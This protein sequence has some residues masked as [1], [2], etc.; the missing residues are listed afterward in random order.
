MPIAAAIV[1]VAFAAGWWWTHRE[2][3]RDELVL[4]GNVDLRQVDLPFNGSERITEILVQEGD[5]VKKGQVLAR[6]ETSRL[7]PQVAQAQAQVAAQQQIVTRLRNGSRP[8]EVA[9]ARANVTL[10]QADTTD[11]QARYSRVKALFD[12][13]N[14]RAVSSQDLDQA[15]AAADAADARLIVSKRGLDLAIAGPRKEDIA[16]AQAR[17]QSNA[18][19]LAFLQQQLSDAELLS[20]TDGV[21]RSRILEPGELASPLKP[22]LSLA[23]IDP[24]WVRAYVAETDLGVVRSGMRATVSVDAFPDRNFGGWIGF[25]SPNAEFTPKTVQ[26]EELRSS[27]VYEIRVFVT[28]PND[29]LRLGMPATVHIAL[30]NNDGTSNQ[31]SSSQVFSSQASH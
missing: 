19:N 21:V 12:K 16:E 8:E 5:R 6:L 14:G 13:S 11:T 29:E 3:S 18:A 10:A 24:K 17:L 7:Q 25:I 20:P 26:T 31:S 28:D 9:Q 15:K 4:Y 2:R 30:K 22:V 23:I 27:L 1:V